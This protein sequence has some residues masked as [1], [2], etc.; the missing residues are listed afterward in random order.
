MAGSIVLSCIPGGWRW[1]FRSV[2]LGGIGTEAAEYPFAMYVLDV[3][4]ADAILIRCDGSYILVDCG[5]YGDDKTVCRVLE[6]QG[7]RYL[8]YAFGTH[9]DSDHIGGYPALLNTV[10]TDLFLL[11]QLHPSLQHDADLIA[12]ETI[13]Q[14]KRIPIRTVSAGDSFAVNR[15]KIEV[16]SPKAPTENSNDSSLVLK[17]TYGKTSFLLMGDAGKTVEEDLI[18]GRSDLSADVLKVGHHGSASGTTDAFLDAVSPRYAA[19][20]V[21]PDSS[22]LPK[23]AV[24]SRLADHGAEIYR[25]D[26]DGTLIFASDGETV[27]VITQYDGGNRSNE[28]LDY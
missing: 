7:G 16:L 21:G 8:T 27:T 14:D 13:L 11:P 18:A 20:S 3:G 4:K 15:G 12:A 17:F 22:H 28:N 25:T 5:E 10:Q 19:V 24:L 9:P 23:D 26:T 2:G 1:A 6:Q